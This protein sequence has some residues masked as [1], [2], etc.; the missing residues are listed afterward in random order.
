VKGWK[1]QEK[2]GE[3]IG[4]EGRKNYPHNLTPLGADEIHSPPK[5]G[6]VA[7]AKRR[8]GGLFKD[9][10]YRLKRSASRAFIRWLRVFEQ[11]TRAL[12]ACPSLLRR[13]MALTSFEQQA[14]SA[15]AIF[16]CASGADSF[17]PSLK[18]RPN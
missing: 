10:Q 13:G 18:K 4:P 6:G 15:G 17:T 16:F 2:E 3:Y 11:T 12:R 8:R 1:K 5:L 14:L 9:E 7:F